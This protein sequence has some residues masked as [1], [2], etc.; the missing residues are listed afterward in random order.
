MVLCDVSK[1]VLLEYEFD[2]VGDSYCDLYYLAKD[3][4]SSLKCKRRCG[5][6][7]IKTVFLALVMIA[8]CTTTFAVLTASSTN[9]PRVSLQLNEKQH[10]NVQAGNI[11]FELLGDEIDTPGVPRT[12]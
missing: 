1:N 11:K 7:K 6:M 3:T 5:V 9:S 2:C 10:G 12:R 8:A 4:L